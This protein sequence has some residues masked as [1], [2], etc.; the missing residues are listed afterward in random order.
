MVLLNAIYL[1]GPWKDQFTEENTAQRSFYLRDGSD[2]S[3]PMMSQTGNFAFLERKG[4]KIVRLPYGELEKVAAYV[5]LPSKDS[6]LDSLVESLNS[7]KWKNWITDMESSR[8][9]I[10]LP[11]FE[12]QFESKLNEPLQD[13]GMELAF[14]KVKANLTGIINLPTQNAY[15]SNV[16][17]K[18]FLEVSEKGTQAAAATSVKIGLT[19]IGPSEDL[20]EIVV[21]RPFLFAIRHEETGALLFLGEVLDPQEIKED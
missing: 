10:V 20:F 9:R 2:K 19:S 21:D 7:E 5:V 12:L 3:L 1:E 16:R 17:H 15:I 13:L 8:G 18:T 11:K 4:T 14:D 6:G